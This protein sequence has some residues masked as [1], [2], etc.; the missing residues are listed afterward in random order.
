MH[1]YPPR[2]EVDVEAGIPKNPI[3]PPQAIH[4]TLNT[5]VTKSRAIVHHGVRIPA[6]N[7]QPVLR[8]TPDSKS[9]IIDRP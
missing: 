7:H 6:V 3:I 1:E 9:R 8:I 5:G 2:V 4:V